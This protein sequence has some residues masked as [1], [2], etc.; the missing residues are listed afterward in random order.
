MQ[1]I[2]SFSRWCGLLTAVMFAGCATHKAMIETPV[3]TFPF[4][5]IYADRDI[6]L[7]PAELIEAVSLAEECG[8]QDVATIE[9]FYI[10][11]TSQRRICVTSPKRVVGRN[12]RYDRLYMNRIGW[13][14]GGASPD[15]KQLG[16][17]W[18]S[19]P[20]K[21][22]L[23]W[24]EYLIANKPVHIQICDGVSIAAA[25]KMIT[26]VIDGKVR[27]ENE[28]CRLAFAA[29]DLSMLDAVLEG[30]LDG[31]EGERDGTFQLSLRSDH[32]VT[33]TFQT[34]QI[35]VTQVSFFIN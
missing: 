14:E 15:D 29:L 21:R 5:T 17:F 6:K 13:T 4:R 27:F 25:D 12:T 32:L 2:L 22:A 3:T 10:M 18:V 30:E 11:P 7:S 33:F 19:K 8:L 20:Y 23:L 16:A 34:G 24:R 1:R 31:T 35:V 28:Q 9:T 26:L